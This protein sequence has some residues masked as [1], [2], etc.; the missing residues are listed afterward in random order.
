M[1]T[2]I[3]PNLCN[4]VIPGVNKQAFISKGTFNYTEVDQWKIM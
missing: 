2:D 4:A 3:P 1:L